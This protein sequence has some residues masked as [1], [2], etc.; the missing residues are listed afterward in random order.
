MFYLVYVSSASQLFTK[1]K[2]R[3]LLEQ[4]HQENAGLGSTRMPP[5]RMANLCA[6]EWPYIQGHWTFRSSLRQR[7]GWELP[8]PPTR[9]S[10][11]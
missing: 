5:S 8:T 6:A 9:G 7:Q 10:T 3:A 2:S 1:L 4:G 11:E